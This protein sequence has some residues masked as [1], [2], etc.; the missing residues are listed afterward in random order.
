MNELFFVVIGIIG[1]AGLGVFLSGWFLHVI[2]LD[3]GSKTHSKSLSLTLSSFPLSLGRFGLGGFA[4][5]VTFLIEHQQVKFLSYTSWAAIIAF[6]GAIVFI[7]M[8]RP[9]IYERLLP[10]L[11]VLFSKDSGENFSNHSSFVELRPEFIPSSILMGLAYALVISSTPI[12]VWT[13]FFFQDFRASIISAGTLFSMVG[14]LIFQFSV[15]AKVS[16]LFDKD[17]TQ[18]AQF[19]N[20]AMF[21]LLIPSLLIC[22]GIVGFNLRFLS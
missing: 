15:N 17:P 14:S 8:F 22:V 19:L 6:F 9:W 10:K 20:A 5:S 1:F 16:T 12:S 3:F 7:K 21:W 2:F 11:I 18:V 4:F 13:A